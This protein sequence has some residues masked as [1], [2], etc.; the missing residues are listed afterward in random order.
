MSINPGGPNEGS[1]TQ[2]F[3]GD[4]DGSNFTM[5]QE[6]AEKLE[7]QNN[8]WVDF[9]RDNYVGVTWQNI[10]KVNGN[11]LFMGWMANWNY[12]QVVPTQKW[13]SSMT[14]AR[15]VGLV[16]TTNGYRLTSTPVEDVQTLMQKGFD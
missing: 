6:F 4:F 10:K 9:S 14:I 8:F 5:D 12:A 13:R 15:E 1:A 3:I 16:K 7:E 11:K 2:Y